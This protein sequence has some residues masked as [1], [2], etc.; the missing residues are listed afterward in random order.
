MRFAPDL[1]TRCRQPELMD[2]PALD[3]ETHRQALDGLARLNVFSRSS[4]LLWPHI[5][6]LSNRLENRPLRLL[7]IA[8]GGGDVAIGLWRKAVSSKLD[9]EITGCDI[10]E[11][12]LQHAAVRAKTA[13]AQIRFSRLDVLNNDIAET[14]DVV[15]CSLFLHHLEKGD[16]VRLLQQMAK[17][18]K[19]LVLINDLRRTQLAWWG[20]YLLGRLVTRSKV[21]HTDGPLSVQA[22]FTAQE[23]LDLAKQAGLET[24]AIETH[25]WQQRFVMVFENKFQ[26]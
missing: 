24:A 6:R 21:V 17:V 16:A 12:A 9:L 14:Y 20:A 2:D 10:S 1:K 23:A 7:D 3:A 25:F 19:H 4:S 15:A 22:A 26:L 11:T 18:A 8:C 13:G 5:R